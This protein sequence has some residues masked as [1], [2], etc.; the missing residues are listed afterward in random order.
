MQVFPL[1]PKEPKNVVKLSWGIAWGAPQAVEAMRWRNESRNMIG[2][3]NEA[4]TSPGGVRR[5]LRR[6]RYR[7]ATE[8]I[9]GLRRPT[10]QGTGTSLKMSMTKSSMWSIVSFVLA[11]G[12]RVQYEYAR[13]QIKLLFPSFSH[14]ED[15]LCAKF[16][17]HVSPRSW[18]HQ[19][20]YTGIFTRGI[21]YQAE[22]SKFR[23]HIF[24]RSVGY[25]TLVICI[26]DFKFVHQ[27]P[28]FH[29]FPLVLGTLLGFH[30]RVIRCLAK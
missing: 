23:E 2:N 28:C 30:L 19:K 12:I 22:L 27:N 9:W 13:N 6:L 25:N 3:P 16:D 17:P 18:V 4:R 1:H 7:D 10:F 26:K 29:C 11:A 14:F 24:N 15:A 5:L 20:L 21:N 8:D